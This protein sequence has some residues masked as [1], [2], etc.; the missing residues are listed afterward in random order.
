MA[1]RALRDLGY[2]VVG[3]AVF[4][5]KGEEVGGVKD[6]AFLTPPFYVTHNQPYEGM[7]L[8]VFKSVLG[9]YGFKLGEPS[10]LGLGIKVEDI[11]AENID[12]AVKCY[13]ILSQEDFKEELR[14]V[15][16]KK[17][18]TAMEKVERD[19]GMLIE[20]PVEKVSQDVQS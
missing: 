5:S 2:E 20:K 15:A 14:R 6:D 10:L 19:I 17:Y 12:K 11:T 9:E 1:V 16:E 18:N 4:D 13:N 3:D 8:K 7:V